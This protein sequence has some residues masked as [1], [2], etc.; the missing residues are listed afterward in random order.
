MLMESSAVCLF[1]CF[2]KYEPLAAMARDGLSIKEN[3]SKYILLKRASGRG[4]AANSFIK[5]IDSAINLT[6]LDD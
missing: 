6:Q 1:V 3:T 2:K 5:E 4:A